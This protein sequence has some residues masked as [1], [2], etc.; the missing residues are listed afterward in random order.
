VTTAARR[1]RL[2]HLLHRGPTTVPALAE[3]LAVSA[4]TAYRDIAALRDAGHDIQASPGPGGGV[5]IAPDSRPRPVHFEVAEIVG[6]ALSVAILRATPGAPFAQS[7]EAALDRARRALSSERQRAMRRLER[8]IL[9]G[10]PASRRVLQS[11]GPVE[12]TLL[13]VFEGCFTGAHEMTFGYVDSCGAATERRIECI[14]LV[15]HAPA[16][17]IVAWDLDRGAPR[18]FRLDRITAPARGAALAEVHPL[19]EAIAQACP[20]DEAAYAGWIGTPIG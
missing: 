18:M 8:R 17:Y 9:I 11:L 13:A 14:A 3:A 1:E 10:A 4:R 15:L 20:E 5:R 2:L 7:A 16:W 19:A 12:N 6:L